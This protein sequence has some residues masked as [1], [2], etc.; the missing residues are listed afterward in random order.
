MTIALQKDLS[1]HKSFQVSEAKHRFSN[2]WLYSDQLINNFHEFS[3]FDVHMD[4]SWD[5]HDLTSF[6]TSVPFPKTC[7]LSFTYHQ[8]NM[9]RST[10]AV[11]A[12]CYNIF[13]TFG[14]LLALTIRFTLLAIS[15][16]QGF[17]LSNSL[18]K[19]L[20]SAEESGEESNHERSLLS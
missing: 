4:D 19:K 12:S 17:S 3:T 20:Y 11:R 10:K 8:Q 13:T 9:L 18:I 16:I 15:H 14:S 7:P 5:T 1:S 2:Y 6:P